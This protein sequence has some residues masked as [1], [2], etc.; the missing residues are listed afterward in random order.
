[1]DVTLAG[2]TY[3]ARRWPGCAAL[4]LAMA[5]LAVGSL[6]VGT[7]VANVRLAFP[8]ETP[9]PPYYARIS[10]E[11]APRTAQWAAIVFYRDPSCVPADFNLLQFFDI[12]RAFGCPLTIEGFE[13]W[14]NGP[15]QDPAPIEVKSRGLGAVPVW[16]VFPHELDAAMADGVLTI[17]ELSA[18]PSLQTGAAHGFQEVLHPSEAARSGKL[19]ITASGSSSNAGAF[20]LQVSASRD[21]ARHVKISFR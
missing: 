2:G 18:L 17:G 12:P 11:G 10:S 13:I 3:L 14:Q 20:Q 16:F 5:A 21:T 1:M 9:G 6:P 4:V 7:A 19:T 15:G 8:E